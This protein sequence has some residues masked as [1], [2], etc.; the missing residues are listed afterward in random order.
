MKNSLI[1]RRI[2]HTSY[3]QLELAQLS[4]QSQEHSTVKRLN[5]IVVILLHLPLSTKYEQ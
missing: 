5:P 4:G 3:D 1:E 2:C